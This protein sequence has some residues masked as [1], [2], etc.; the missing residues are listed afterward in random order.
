MNSTPQKSISSA[1]ESEEVTYEQCKPPAS[2]P[3]K[4]AL[5]VPTKGDGKN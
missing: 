5:S 2:V 4:T 1:Q 3:G